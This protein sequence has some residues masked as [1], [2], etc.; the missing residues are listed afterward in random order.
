MFLMGQNK[1]IGLQLK[2]KNYQNLPPWLLTHIFRKVSTTNWDL[3]D[4]KLLSD[5]N[6]FT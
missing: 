6:R 2:A 4:L 3:A 1:I 5:T